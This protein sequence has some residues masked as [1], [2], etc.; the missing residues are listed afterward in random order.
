[1]RERIPL[2]L[3]GPLCECRKRAY[4]MLLYYG[5]S[6]ISGL[7][8]FRLQ[9]WNPFCWGSDFRYIRQAGEIAYWLHNLTWFAAH[10]FKE[11]EEGRFW[12]D[13]ESMVQR[14]PEAQRNYKQQFLRE[15]HA[16]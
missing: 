7:C 6:E 12:R 9:S 13:Y 8:S 4:R 16:H 5:M 1:M 15:L 11:F 14:V 2:P 10:D 3:I